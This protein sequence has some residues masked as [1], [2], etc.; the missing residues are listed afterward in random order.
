MI[1]SAQKHFGRQIP[2]LLSTERARD[3]NRVEWKLLHAHGNIP[4]TLPAL[5]NELFSNL[6]HNSKGKTRN[7]RTPVSLRFRKAPVVRHGLLPQEAVTPGDATLA[8]VGLHLQ[9]HRESR[10]GSW[11][12]FE[13]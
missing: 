7:R 3:D 2:V 4:P 6:H 11:N 9:I 13:P 10:T 12:F 5:N 1:W 8:P